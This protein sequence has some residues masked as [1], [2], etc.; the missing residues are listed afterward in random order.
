MATL[1]ISTSA[2]RHNYRLLRKRASTPLIPV[3]KAD[4]YGHGAADVLLPLR[5]EGACL[6]ALANERELFLLL[7]HKKVKTSLQKGGISF[8]LLGDCA[9]SAVEKLSRL[10][11]ILSVHSLSYALLLEKIL[12]ATTA[13]P[14]PV[15]L[16]LETGMNRL[17]LTEAEARAVCALPHLRAVGVY[18][19]FAE[20]ATDPARTLAQTAAFASLSA[21]LS[22]ALPL[23]GAVRHLSAGA[24]V[25]RYGALG[26]DAARVGLPLYGVCPAGTE[27][28]GLLP[29]MR[30]AAR[31]MTVKHIP[32]GAGMGY[33]PFRAPHP[34]RVAVIDVGY[35]D[36]LPPSAAERG[37]RIWVRGRLCPLAGEVCMDR[38]FAEVGDAPLSEGDEVTVFGNGAGDTERFARESGASPYHL[39]VCRSSRTERRRE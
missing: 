6:F 3:L 36:G 21:S 32:K 33:G 2:L 35:A 18:S 23:S 13:P 8:L 19:H 20:A 9:P 15:H 25:L 31:V 34:M 14:L 16:K 5:E 22:A 37:A 11:V 30:L 24:A 39:L 1:S 38:A 4:A 29:V 12:S 28:D 26:F 7:N 17:G 10:P 27:G